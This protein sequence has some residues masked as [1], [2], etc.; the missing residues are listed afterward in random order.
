MKNSLIIIIFIFQ[1]NIAFTQSIDINKLDTYFSTLEANNKF[2]GSVAVFKDNE[3]VFNRQ[4]GFSEIATQTRPDKNTKYRIGS[5]SKTLTAVLVFKAIEQSKISLSET[6]DS[7]FPSIKNADK[8]T[9]ANLLNH[10]SGIHSYTDDKNEYL[11][12]H[13]QRKSEKEMVS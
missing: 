6:I 10:R 3:I 5:V 11:N 9:T 2:M 13:T 1:I 12:Y 7:F 8:I 4:Y